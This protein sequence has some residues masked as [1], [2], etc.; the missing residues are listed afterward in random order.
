MTVIQ[1]VAIPSAGEDLESWARFRALLDE[2]SSACSRSAARAQGR[3]R[4]GLL[5]AAAMLRM[6]LADLDRASVREG[7]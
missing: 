2:V 4:A 1:A 3:D 6:D 7:A 5:M